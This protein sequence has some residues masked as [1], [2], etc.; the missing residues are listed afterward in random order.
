MRSKTGAPVAVVLVL[1]A[2]M[3]GELFA[4]AQP[5]R[6]ATGGPIKITWAGLPLK[7]KG[8]VVYP[9]VEEAITQ[10]LDK[11]L[12]IK[13][14]PVKVD[15]EAREQISLLFAAGEIPDHVLSNKNNMIQ[16]NDEGL[17][18]Q[19]PDDMVKK[20]A[21]T[22]YKDYLTGIVGSY[23]KQLPSYDS[24]TGNWIG[25][26]NGIKE[27]EA[28]MVVRTDW[29][30]KVGAKMPTTAAEFENVAR[31]FT[32]ADPD[33]NGK[34]DTYG[35]GTGTGYWT[36]GLNFLLA[37]FG[38]EH[39][40][41]PVMGKDGKITFQNLTEGYK[42]FLKFVAGLYAK[43]YLYPDVT[44]PDRVSIGSLFSDGIIGTVVDT[45]TW[46]LPKYRQGSWFDLAFE[47][48][49]KATFQYA[50][51]LTA[52]GYTPTWEERAAVWRYHC[53]GK[54]VSDEKLIKILQ[55]IDLQLKEKYYHNLIWSGIEGTHFQFD[56]QGMRQ[57]IGDYTSA[58]KQGELG[59][60]FYLTNIKYGWMLGASF[61]K[62][63]ETQA[64]LQIS[65]KSVKPVLG[66]EWVLDSQM[67]VGADVNRVFEEYTW[68]AL[69]GKANFAG[70]WDTYVKAWLGGGGREMI[71]EANRKYQAMK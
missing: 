71:D 34:K 14:E 33:G 9:L 6:S 52:P 56:A 43:G 37:S 32:E 65:W 17:F 66:F 42:D 28:L 38:Y 57:F 15:P 40:N 26:P 48:N 18:R 30:E 45:W 29:L 7:T 53:V 44:L 51:P 21:P 54:D 16:W 3:A 39:P 69:T 47:K 11:A 12:G 46:V 41:V 49:P 10:E 31:L 24:K 36:T 25:L 67:K 58:E 55:V 35:L 22:Y 5:E 13:L 60:K 63:A 61:G 50:P 64:D 68:K 27:L 20:Y 59:S 2:A 23:A 62:A 19:I 1:A 4:G 70:D 8:G